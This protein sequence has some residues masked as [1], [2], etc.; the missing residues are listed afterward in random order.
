MLSR[1]HFVSLFL[2]S[3]RVK[4]NNFLCL[5]GMIS[6]YNNN[7]NIR[8]NVSMLLNPHFVLFYRKKVRPVKESWNVAS[9]CIGSSDKSDAMLRVVKVWKISTSFLSESIQYAS[10]ANDEVFVL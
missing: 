5:S 6:R 4:C 2:L 7:N 10:F 9:F 3:L 8:H 1:F